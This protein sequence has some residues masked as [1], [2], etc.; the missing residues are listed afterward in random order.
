MGKSERKKLVSRLDKVFSEYIRKRDGACVICGKRAPEVRLTCGHLFSRVAYSTRWDE[1]LAFC[2]CTGCNNRHEYDPGLFIIWFAEK[3]GWDKYEEGH[4]K[5][6]TPVKYTNGQLVELIEYWK[7]RIAWLE[8][9]ERVI[10]K[11]SL[12]NKEQADGEAE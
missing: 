9:A 1:S 11:G 7:N 6:R 10:N 5:H 2:Q 4:K 3:F 12:L 8:Y